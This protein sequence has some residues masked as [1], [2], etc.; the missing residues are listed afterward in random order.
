M[1]E[2]GSSRIAAAR[3]R[4]FAAKQRLAIV[5]TASFVA[6]AALAW[7]SHPGKSSSSSTLSSDATVDQS[8]TYF[9]EESD[10]DDFGGFDAFS[11]IAPSNGVAPQV[12]TGVS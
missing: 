3:Q 11:A 5:A 6:V 10:D 7:A 8:G 9:D 2:Q 1:T 12:Q 4:A